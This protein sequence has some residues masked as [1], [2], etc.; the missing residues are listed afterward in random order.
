MKAGA[1]LI[2]AGFRLGFRR[3]LES[4][5]SRM[6]NCSRVRTLFVQGTALN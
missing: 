6:Q 1:G 4:I 5:F 3:S 2:R